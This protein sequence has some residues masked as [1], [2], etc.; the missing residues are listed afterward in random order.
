MERV[1][2]MAGNPGNVLRNRS[3]EINENGEPN[4]HRKGIMN[5]GKC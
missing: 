1:R 4:A 3:R 2:F 5:K